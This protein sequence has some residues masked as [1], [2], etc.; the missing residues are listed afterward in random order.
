VNDVEERFVNLSN[1]V[2]ERDTLDV[3][4]LV[5]VELRGIREGE[6]VGGDA[7]DVGA[8]FS[9]VCV[10]RV[11]EDLE[12]RS[13][14]ALTGL[15]AAAFADEICAG[16]RTGG[17]GEDVTHEEASRKIRTFCRVSARYGPA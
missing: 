2:K 13:G 5:I 11:E 15:A 16:D 7:A 4:L 3:P 14:H 9:I 1:V 12:T 8:G 6:C 17:D 10:D